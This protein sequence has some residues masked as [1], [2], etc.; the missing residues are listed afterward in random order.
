MFA[1]LGLPNLGYPRIDTSGFDGSVNYTYNATTAV[2]SFDLSSSPFT[3][4]NSP[5]DPSLLVF[6]PKTFEIHFKTDGAGNVTDG[7]AGAD[8][9]I[10]GAVDS[11][12]NFTPDDGPSVTLLSGEIKQFG[13]QD[14]GTTTDLYEFRFGVD[15][16][17]LLGS[18]AGGDA[19]MTMSLENSTFTGSFMQDFSGAIV[20]ATV[21]RCRG[22]RTA[23]RSTRRRS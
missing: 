8:F 15:A 16:G 7:V 12:N 9:V 4:Q 18:F 1:L 2:G 17:S 11:D 21:G 10:T 22:R 14:T 20:K 23:L 6:G 3:V 13:S 19:G 5:T